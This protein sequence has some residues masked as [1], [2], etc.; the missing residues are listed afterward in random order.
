[1]PP[2]NAVRAKRAIARIIKLLR[3][4]HRG[5]QHAELL[6]EVFGL[7]DDLLLYGS[8]Q[9]W[10]SYMVQI[11]DHTAGLK[12]PSLQLETY[13]SGQLYALIV[14]CC[15][16]V[17]SCVVSSQDLE[18][19]CFYSCRADCR[20]KAIIGGLQ[21]FIQKRIWTRLLR[22]EDLSC[23]TCGSPVHVKFNE[24][25]SIERGA[26]TNTDTGGTPRWGGLGKLWGQWARK[27]CVRE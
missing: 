2:K 22:G 11:V 20:V 9:Q 1:M 4:I 23:P 26:D 24:E 8:P 13:V 17:P 15:F 5:Q 25:R 14:L 10:A 3:K 16:D 6:Q 19:I 7:A 21:P 27:F 18:P 12:K